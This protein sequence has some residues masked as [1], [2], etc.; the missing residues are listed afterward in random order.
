MGLDDLLENHR[1]DDQQSR[2]EGACQNL[3]HSFSPYLSTA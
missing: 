2:E 3:G 1:Q